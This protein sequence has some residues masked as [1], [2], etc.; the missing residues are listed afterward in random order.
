MLHRRTNSLPLFRKQYFLERGRVVILVSR[1]QLFGRPLCVGFLE[2]CVT[3]EFC[4]YRGSAER[5]QKIEEQYFRQLL[6][7]CKG[8]CADI[9]AS[10]C[11]GSIW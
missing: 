7:I 5:A 11:L 6:R 1:N 10:S 8:S 3:L 2:Q 4:A 9:R